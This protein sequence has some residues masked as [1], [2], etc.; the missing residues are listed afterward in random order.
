LGAPSLLED[1]IFPPRINTFNLPSGS[2]ARFLVFLVTSVTVAL[3]FGRFIN[4][5]G[6]AQDA[7]EASGALISGL[8][9]VAVGGLIATLLFLIHP[10]TQTTRL[11]L[12]SELDKNSSVNETVRRL[13]NELGISSPRVLIDDDI[14]NGDAV[15]FGFARFRTVGLG[16]GSLIL[17]VKRPLEF[18]ARLAHEL[19]HFKN[20]DVV[21]A[22]FARAIIQ[23]LSI[24]VG[25]VFFIITMKSILFAAELYRTLGADFGD[26]DSKGRFFHSVIITVL[27]RLAYS[28]VYFVFGLILWG[29]VLFLEH[30]SFLRNRE[31]LA[32]AQAAACVGENALRSALGRRAQ[33]RRFEW[34]GP[35]YAPFDAHPQLEERR[36][37]TEFPERIGVPSFTWLFGFGYLCAAM[38]YVVGDIL[39]TV[40]LASNDAFAPSKTHNSGDAFILILNTHPIVGIVLLAIMSVLPGVLMFCILAAIARLA[41]VDAIEPVR[42]RG[43]WFCKRFL[44]GLSFGVGFVCGQVINPV[45]AYTQ[46]FD[47]NLSLVFNR[48]TIV[49]LTTIIVLYVSFSLIVLTITGWLVTGSRDRRINSF[50]WIV[51]FFLIENTTI[52]ITFGCAFIILPSLQWTGFSSFNMIVW[53]AI[54]LI[55]LIG[56]TKYLRGGRAAKSNLASWLF[57]DVGCRGRELLK[58]PPPFEPASDVLI[59]P[60]P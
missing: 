56:F 44:E 59:R 16:K 22:F 28:L 4:G 39:D 3:W 47:Y 33:G 30:R 58:T 48:F 5:Y 6:P 13:S 31:L 43:I 49:V 8:I 10:F 32:D 17:A 27:Y 36:S 46:W 2:G 41:I 35:I 45:T 12:S 15:A 9:M 25:I 11:R 57:A 24:C 51:L 53:I 37:L 21:Y 1:S 23:S 55:A 38:L 34:L 52:G 26:S 19:G 60:G 7:T 18:H 40:G 42:K 50:Q 54:Y 20:G 14:T 29:I